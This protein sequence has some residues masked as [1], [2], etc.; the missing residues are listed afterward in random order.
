MASAP[1][2]AK[3]RKLDPITAPPAPAAAAGTVVAAP[4]K[5]DDSANV[6]IQFQSPEGDPTGPQLDVPH[7]VT[8]QQLETLLNGLLQQEERLPY[9]FFINEQELAAELGAHLKKNAV[10]VE[11]VLRVVYQPQAVFKVRPVARCSATIPGHTEAVLTVNFSPDGKRLVSGGGDCTVRFW[12]LGTQ[13][14]K[15]VGKNHT[16]WV[17][18][19]AWSPD[20]ALIASGDHSGVIWIWDPTTGKALG[21]CKGH[22]KFISSL[23]WEPAHVE[24]PVRRFASGSKDGTIRVW[25]ALGRKLMFTMSSHTQA[26]TAV[27]WGG[28]GLLY[29]A[30][31][32]CSINVWAAEDG[33]L[34]RSL[35]GHGHWVNTMSLS[36]DYALR[37][38]AFDHTGKAPE[39]LDRAKIAAKERYEAALAGKKERLVTGSDDFTLCL[40]EPSTSKTPLA[41]MTGHQQLVNQVTFSP[42]GRWI[43]SASFD[44]SVKLWDGVT[45]AFVSTLRAHVGPV[46][47]V[48]WSSDSRLAVS[49][50]KDS[51]LKIWDMRSKKVLVDLPGHADEVFTVDWSPDGAAVASGGK[52]RVLKL[53]RQ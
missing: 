52:D 25:D 23:A 29:S 34:V 30:A 27:R 14:P 39:D 8:P 31:R 3:Q 12:D 38:G 1:P 36:S 28:D 45:G 17:L 41:R 6:I 24:L 18:A 53:W 10:S 35:K 21:Q 2:P 19:V 13:T 50:S 51:T 46:Y 47:Q 9:S 11:A 20:A 15:S 43:L 22:R 32:D 42:D 48:A 7:D 37:T 5:I 33:K 16:A 26:V 4:P 44:K 49:G 40:W